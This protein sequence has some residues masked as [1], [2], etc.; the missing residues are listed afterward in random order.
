[1]LSFSFVARAYAQET[2]HMAF[3]DANTDTMTY[4]LLG[5]RFYAGFRTAF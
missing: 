5:R 4:D 3:T 1:M 2:D